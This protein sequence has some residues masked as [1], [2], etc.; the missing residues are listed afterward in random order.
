MAQKRNFSIVG[1][2]DESALVRAVAERVGIR[3]LFA[4]E[5]SYR[6]GEMVVI[7]P[8]NP[9][10]HV[11][12][13]TNIWEHAPSVFRTLLLADA[14]RNAGATR[15]D[16]LAPWIAY[17]RQDRVTVAGEAPAGIVIGRLLAHTFDHMTT[18]DAHSPEFIRSF[19]GRLVS[20]MLL[21]KGIQS[22]R[23]RISLVVAP[24]RGAT[25]RAKR[26]A[27]SLRVPFAVITKKRVNGRVVSSCLDIREKDVLGARALLVD[28]IADSGGT[29]ESAVCVLRSA[30]AASVSAFVS[31]AV[32]LTALRSSAKGMLDH[33]DA[34]FDHKTKK[35]SP[36]VL[37]ALTDAMPR[38]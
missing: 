20:V 26:V 1:F 14:L 31:H 33:V 4:N 29:L 15:V 6:A 25:E 5:S 22:R 32:D 27:R 12:L 18:L 28:D 24:D 2:T 30:G 19:R 10:R 13:V 7:G 17:G 35:M 36:Q 37:T 16:L 38:V 21:Q 11:L 23:H 3:P 8:V 9:F 34:A